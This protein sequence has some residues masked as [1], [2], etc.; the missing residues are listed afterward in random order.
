M[1]K[2]R[3]YTLMFIFLFSGFCN[4]SDEALDS[5]PV[6]VGDFGPS[7]YE[8]HFGTVTD[9]E[10]ESIQEELKEAKAETLKK[11]KSKEKKP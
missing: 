10:L 1:K 5:A 9:N 6:N 4:A 8:Q 11:N 3:S 2:L 7:P